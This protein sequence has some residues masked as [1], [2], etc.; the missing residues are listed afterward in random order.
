MTQ[1]VENMLSAE[2][3]L[4]FVVVNITNPKARVAYTIL[5]VF[6]FT[7]RSVFIFGFGIYK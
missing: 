7:K 3:T 2:N 5:R 4:P 1:K 6:E